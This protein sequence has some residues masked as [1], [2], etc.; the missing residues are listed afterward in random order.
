[1]LVKVRLVIMSYLSDVQETLEGQTYQ[2]RLDNHNRLNFAK[3]LGMTYKNMDEEIN[4]DEV[5]KAYAEKY[6]KD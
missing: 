4:A 1:M 6:L 3:Y 5:Y 2:E